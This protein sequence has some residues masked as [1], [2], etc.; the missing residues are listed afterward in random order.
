MRL[1]VAIIVCIW[2]L[3]K[4]IFIVFAIWGEKERWAVKVEHNHIDGYTDDQTAQCKP[5]GQVSQSCCW[6]VI[7]LYFYFSLPLCIPDCF[8]YENFS[9]SFNS[10]PSGIL[11]FIVCIGNI[12]FLQCGLSHIVF[13]N[14]FLCAQ[15]KQLQQVLQRKYVLEESYLTPWKHSQERL[16]SFQTC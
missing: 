8:H 11:V 6:D 12:K 7:P 5:W 14:H 1:T 3:K 15:H 9:C 16:L 13:L 4:T 10:I 2:F